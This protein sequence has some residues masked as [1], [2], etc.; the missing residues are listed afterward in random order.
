MLD[1][2]GEITTMEMTGK[3]V[4]MSV[5]DVLQHAERSRDKTDVNWRQLIGI[6]PWGTPYLVEAIR[7]PA[8]STYSYR[9]NVR[10]FGPNRRDDLGTKDDLQISAPGW[11]QAPQQMTPSKDS[12]S[13]A[14]PHASPD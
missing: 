11:V 6:D 4:P 12:P 2:R 5:L 14:L 9:M 8:Y 3:P 13:R 1:I 7:D 10:S